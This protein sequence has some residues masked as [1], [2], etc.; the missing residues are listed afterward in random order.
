METEADFFN[1]IGHKQP[2]VQGRS[3]PRV[4]KNAHSLIVLDHLRSWLNDRKANAGCRIS[5]EVEHVNAV[6]TASGMDQNQPFLGRQRLHQ[7]VSTDDF[8]DPFHVVGEHI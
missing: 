5:R 2:F 8:H 7:T 1:R 4:C 3:R 6:F